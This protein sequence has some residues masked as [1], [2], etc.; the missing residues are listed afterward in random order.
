MKRNTT[1]I[2]QELKYLILVCQKSSLS[3]WSIKLIYPAGKNALHFHVLCHST[4]LFI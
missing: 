3:G 1:A 4:I 2:L